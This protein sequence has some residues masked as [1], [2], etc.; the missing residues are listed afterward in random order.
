MI[1]LTITARWLTAS[2]GFLLTLWAAA[3]L[4]REVSS[5]RA[6]QEFDNARA[7]ATREE[8]KAQRKLEADGQI[9]FSLWSKA[10]ARTYTVSLQRTA[11]SPVAILCIE[12]LN[13]RVPVFPG[14]GEWTLNRGAGWIE[15]TAFPGET[16]NIGIAAH[17]DGF[18]RG[19][20]DTVSGDMIQLTT[21]S[22][23]DTY[24]VDQVEIVDPQNVSV[25]QPR[26]VPSLTLVTCYPFYFVG[27]APKR[28]I[29][30]AALRGQQ[31][32]KKVWN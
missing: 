1:P 25:L 21:L 20:K 12:K 13:L 28:F 3:V 5:W 23:T 8:P 22:S 9:D 30:H 16:G 26:A 7:E 4:Y 11:G 17:R 32:I 31:P 24:E 27:E 15:G 6:L 29:V 18:F 19:L 10:R 2:G 14:T